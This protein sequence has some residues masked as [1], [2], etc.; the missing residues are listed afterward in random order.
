MG[1]VMFALEGAGAH[2]GQRPRLFLEDI[3]SFTERSGGS[4]EQGWVWHTALSQVL[5]GWTPALPKPPLEVAPVSLFRKEMAHPQR[6]L[7]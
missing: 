5:L 7:S 4:G 3:T 6:K 1:V 2:P